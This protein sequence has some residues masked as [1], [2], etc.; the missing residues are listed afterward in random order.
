MR[1]APVTALALGS[2]LL[3]A[4]CV[5]NGPPTGGETGTTGLPGS[6][7]PSPTTAPRLAG[8]SQDPLLTEVFEDR[9]ERAEIGPSY[10][11]ASA[12]WVLRDGRLCAEHARNR[13]I[14]LSRRL[15]SN[16]RI[17]LDAQSSSPE[18]DLKVEAWGD[19]LSGAT[20]TSYTNATS[21][22]FVLGGW[23]NTL[24]VLARLDEHGNDRKVVRVQ[25]G[26]E[27]DRE[28]PV[29][30]DRTYHFRIER[31]DGHTV[32]WWVNDVRLTSFD[33]ASPLL[34]L[35]HDHVGFN[36][37]DAPVCFDNLVVTPL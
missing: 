1:C 36:D 12:A 31:S 8:P 9:F 2:L 5:P 28:R 20:H 33:D 4:S 17:E 14:W 34:G 37:W 29:S 26:S 3:T 13:G 6:G 30:P 23:K 15:P 16:A 10:R 25:R 22:L 32:T 7:Q 21:Y 18:G 35:G 24:H 27:D 11:L 19:G